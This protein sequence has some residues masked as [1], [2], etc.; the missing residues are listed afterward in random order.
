[1]PQL[2]PE[3]H[4]LTFKAMRNI[5]I[6]LAALIL[7]GVLACS[8]PMNTAHT[9]TLNVTQAYQTVEANLTQAIAKTSQVNPVPTQPGTTPVPPATDTPVPP[10]AQPDVPKATPTSVCDHASPGS[11]ID[12]TIPDDT[13]QN[14]GFTQ[15]E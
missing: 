7:W 13:D 6:P 1:M 12:I 9:P 8:F 2:P 4:K 11:P 15:R 10:T 5:L 14:M 3:S